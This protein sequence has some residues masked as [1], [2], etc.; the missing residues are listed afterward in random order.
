MLKL[1]F[2]NCMT[3][4]GYVDCQFACNLCN[5]VLA[6]KNW[7]K[8]KGVVNILLLRYCKFFAK[9]VNKKL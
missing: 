8:C 1:C 4:M 6:A 5:N 3:P 2:V 9:C 7:L